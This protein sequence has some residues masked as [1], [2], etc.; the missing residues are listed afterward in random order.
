M[1]GPGPRA[2]RWE[3]TAEP[4]REARQQRRLSR[5]GLAN[6]IGVSAV[7]VRNWEMGRNYPRVDH[8][9]AAVNEL[10]FDPGAMW[11]LVSSSPV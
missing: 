6:K 7:A 5:Q 9:E 11:R 3:F 10:G 1:S 8:L 4:M 2:L